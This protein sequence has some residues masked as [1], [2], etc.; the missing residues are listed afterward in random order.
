MLDIGTDATFHAE[1]L[2][3]QCLQLRH[4]KLVQ[5]KALAVG[6]CPVK[7]QMGMEVRFPLFAFLRRLYGAVPLIPV[8][9]DL[10]GLDAELPFHGCGELSQLVHGSVIVNDDD[11][12]TKR[13]GGLL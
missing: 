12:F 3:G 11:S 6:L 8:D 10:H 9:M 13:L 5:R 7:T 2:C 1:D 4:V